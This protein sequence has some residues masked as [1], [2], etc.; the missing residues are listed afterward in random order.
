MMSQFDVLVMLPILFA[1]WW[2]FLPRT[3]IRFYTWFHK[4]RLHSGNLPNE[5]V[6]R[7]LGVA[8]LVLMAFLVWRSR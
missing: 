4:G 2:V 6:I 1:L 5:P 8:C 7:A 3:V